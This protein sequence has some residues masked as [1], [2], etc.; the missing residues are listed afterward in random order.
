MSLTM[1]TM[2]CCHPGFTCSLSYMEIL[3]TWNQD[4]NITL[5]KTK[6]SAITVLV[7]CKFGTR[8]TFKD[9]NFVD[10]PL[11]LCN[12]Y[13]CYL[14]C[15]ETEW[16]YYWRCIFYCLSL[17]QTTMR[18]QSLSL[19]FLSNPHEMAH[20]FITLIIVESAEL[21]PLWHCLSPSLV[22]LLPPS[23]CFSICP[24]L[25][26]S[27]AISPSLPMSFPLELYWPSLSL[28]LVLSHFSRRLNL[29]TTLL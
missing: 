8:R 13:L 16:L 4:E 12:R 17:C 28:S 22:F 3:H 27:L 18:G 19:S 2:S 20:S 14:S 11:W 26:L 21:F 10:P 1:Y 23:D 6:G 15:T 24:S 25:H 29:S 9:G 7:V 5:L